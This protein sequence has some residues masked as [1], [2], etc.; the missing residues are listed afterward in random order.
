VRPRRRCQDRPSLVP[1]PPRRRAEASTVTGFLPGCFYCDP[2][3]RHRTAGRPRL[4]SVW[5]SDHGWMP[6]AWLARWAAA[7]V[8]TEKQRVLYNGDEPLLPR[9]VTDCWLPGA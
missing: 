1:F 2:R 4:R 7:G 8:T 9:P 6:A 3:P 5:Y